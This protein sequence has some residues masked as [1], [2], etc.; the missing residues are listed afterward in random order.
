MSNWGFGIPGDEKILLTRVQVRDQIVDHPETHYQGSWWYRSKL[1]TTIS[2][3]CGTRACVAGWAVVFA[4]PDAVF[5]DHKTDVR[6]PVM[7]TFGVLTSVSVRIE[8]LARLSLGLTEDQ[9]DYLFD[10][11][12]SHDEVVDAL[13][14]LIEGRED[15]VVWQHTRVTDDNDY[16]DP[17][18]GHDPDE[19]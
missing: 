11:L 9:A 2:G 15:D 3:D 10:G 18:E 4:H 6:V 5:S 19:Y 16:D 13:N 7:G 14:D 8:M 1:S 17:Y 12:R